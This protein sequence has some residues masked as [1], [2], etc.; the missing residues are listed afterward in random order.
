MIDISLFGSTTI[1][2]VDTSTGG[3]RRKIEVSGVKPRRILEILAASLGST[4]TKDVLAEGLWNGRPPASYVASVESYVC[5]LRRTLVQA[6]GGSPLVTGH[7]GYLLDP[8]LVRVDLADARSL[9]RDLGRTSGAALVVGAEQV[10]ELMRG[11]LLADEPFADWATAVRERFDDDLE[12]VLTRAAEAANVLGDP[13]TA[14]RMARTALETKPLSEPAFREVMVAHHAAGAPGQALRTYADLRGL[15]LREL[16]V[17]PGPQT[18]RLYLSILDDAETQELR[19]KDRF[20]VGTLA[21]LLR[22]ALESGARPDPATRSWL[23][24]LGRTAVA[25]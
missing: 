5:V 19:E 24:E 16:G 9:L 21:R 23:A 25:S 4:V 20:E 13:V 10:L 14:L 15:L 3:G 7:G 12:P 6:A 17:E 22:Q 8:D 11:R 2:T 1:S 18:H